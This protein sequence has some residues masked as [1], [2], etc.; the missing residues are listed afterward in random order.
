MPWIERPTHGWIAGT[1]DASA[2][3][4]IDGATVKAKR[5]GFALFRRAR[6]VKTDG[7][8]YFGL[9]NLKPGRYRVWV[10][11]GAKPQ[12]RVEVL[13]EAGKVTRAAP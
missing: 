5:T 7:N 8:G 9:T 13:V 1:L 6:T 3:G 2:A 12:R 4:T 10:E 11:D